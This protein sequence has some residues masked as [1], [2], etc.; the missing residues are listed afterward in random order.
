MQ[1]RT[2]W[3]KHSLQ[4]LNKP[5]LG[6]ILPDSPGARTHHAVVLGS[7]SFE[8]AVPVVAQRE[9]GEPKETKHISSLA[10]LHRNHCV[11]PEPLS[12]GPDIQINGRE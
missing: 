2:V 8:P 1:E 4:H 7:V 6:L 10:R 12:W 5:P 11:F 9:Q 3:G